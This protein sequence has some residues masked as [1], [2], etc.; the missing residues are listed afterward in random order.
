MLNEIDGQNKKMIIIIILHTINNLK[1]KKD[2][3]TMIQLKKIV[4]S[5]KIP[6]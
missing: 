4:N 5:V 6:T 2:C 1:K 3:L